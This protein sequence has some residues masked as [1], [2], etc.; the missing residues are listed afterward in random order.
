MCKLRKVGDHFFTAGVVRNGLGSTTRLAGAADAPFSELPL[1]F[2]MTATGCKYPASR[3]ADLTIF[4]AS[5][6][7]VR[8]SIV[9]LMRTS[10]WTA[11][12][13]CVQFPL[14][15]SAAAVLW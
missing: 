10:T 9:F 1:I 2:D 3:A 7:M 4:S 5:A 11:S 6:F 15:S 8:P 14:D 12:P 13:V